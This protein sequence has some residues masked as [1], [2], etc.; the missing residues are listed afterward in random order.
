M[1]NANQAEQKGDDSNV[2]NTTS[3]IYI[4]KAKNSKNSG[5]Y[6]PLMM[7]CPVRHQNMN[8]NDVK[9]QHRETSSWTHTKCGTKV[10]INEYG[11]VRC[12][13]HHGD[14]FVMWK[15]SCGKHKAEYLE[16]DSQFVAAALQ[17]MLKSIDMPEEQS[18]K[19][20][21][22]LTNHVCKQFDV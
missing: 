10:D 18:M 14:P 13:E 2:Q 4:E 3:V 8:D 7:K 15:W 21:L 1:G 6:V 12:Q 19:W 20:F 5:I 11:Y 9:L 17:E 16:A 22:N